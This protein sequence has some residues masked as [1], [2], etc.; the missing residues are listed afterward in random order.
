M[1]GVTLDYLAVQATV[2]FDGTGSG[3]AVLAPGAGQFWLPTIAHV[4][5]ATLTG[6]GA[7][8]SLHVGAQ[9]I[10]N[11]TTQVDFTFSGV[12]DSSSIVSG[13]VV[14]PGES[15]TAYFNN[16]TPFDTGFLRVIG[17]SSSAPPTVGLEPGF[18]GA[19]FTGNE[20]TVTIAAQPVSVTVS[21]Q[22]IGVTENSKQMFVNQ[23]PVP[24][25]VT[26]AASATSV[27]VAA[28]VGVQLFV[29]TLRV[30]NAS[31]ASPFYP[32]LQDTSGTTL[33]NPAF[34]SES[35]TIPAGEWTPV[36]GYNDFKG[37]P[38]TSGLGIQLKNNGIASSRFIGY[39]TYSK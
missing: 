36:N 16:G 30:E 20:S 24:F 39:L 5:T 38:V 18:P 32:Q 35:G 1:E 31:P 23:P 28:A 13:M 34:N 4:G 21:G 6:N 29:H 9:G 12:S 22:P 15:I 37:A 26:L 7:N 17:V 25:D 14:S 2:T 3:K 33:A 27:L 11:Y 8:C 10:I 19:K